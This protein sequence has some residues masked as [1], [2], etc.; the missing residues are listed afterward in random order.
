M[1]LLFSLLFS[2]LVIDQWEPLSPF[3]RTLVVFNSF[4]LSEI[5]R[6]PES[7]LTFPNS[8]LESLIS[9]KSPGSF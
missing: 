3:N 4:L 2:Y 5:T 8:D 1:Q 6:F 9:P 7:F